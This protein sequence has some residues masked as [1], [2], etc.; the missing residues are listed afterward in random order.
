MRGAEKKD[1]KVFLLSNAIFKKT[2][3]VP[4]PKQLL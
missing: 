4:S 3:L 2:N 1:K